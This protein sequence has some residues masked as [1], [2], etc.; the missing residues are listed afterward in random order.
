MSIKLY[1]EILS[2]LISIVFSRLNRPF[3]GCARNWGEFQSLTNRW[4][5]ITTWKITLRRIIWPSLMLLCWTEIKVWTFR[6]GSKS[7]QMSLNLLTASPK[8]IQ[9]I[10]Q[11]SDNCK[12]RSFTDY[13]KI[14]VFAHFY[15]HYRNCKKKW[16]DFE[17]CVK[18]HTLVSVQ[19]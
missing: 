9:N 14:T 8:T 11:F 5:D 18:V 10:L 6:H 1:Q 13:L 3:R 19:H 2:L 7:I 12:V 15:E 16:G 17:S 4:F